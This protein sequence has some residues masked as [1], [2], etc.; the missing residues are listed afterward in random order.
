VPVSAARTSTAS[1]TP[2]S[3]TRTLESRAVSA[4]SSHTEPRAAT[5]ARCRARGRA[6]TAWLRRGALRKRPRARLRRDDP[7]Q[8]RPRP[9]LRRCRRWPCGRARPLITRS[10]A[11]RLRR[12]SLKEAEKAGKGRGFVS[13]D[14]GSI[15]ASDK[16][17]CLQAFPRRSGI[18]TRC[19]TPRP[20]RVLATATRRA[21]HLRLENQVAMRV[22]GVLRWR[23]PDSNR[24]HHD[25]QSCALP[26]ELSRRGGDLA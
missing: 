23:D 21:S 17:P 19:G 22:C 16:Q 9:Q 1:P 10:S 4:T 11:L 3:Q 26:T 25:F 12:R 13:I 24:G 14:T 15:G 8:L 18:L 5:L 2:P 20:F 7:R 6:R